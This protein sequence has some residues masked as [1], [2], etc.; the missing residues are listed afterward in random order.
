MVL[1]LH[2]LNLKGASVCCV[3]AVSLSVLQ[4]GWLKWASWCWKMPDRHC[5]RHSCGKN[6]DMNCDLTVA[7]KSAFDELVYE[8]EFILTDGVD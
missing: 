2:L 4:C 8:S 1:E 3:G 7:V 6:M 5:G